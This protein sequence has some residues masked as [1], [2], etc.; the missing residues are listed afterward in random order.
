MF[1]GQR[2]G[3]ARRDGIGRRRLAD[4]G[5]T[6]DGWMATDRTDKTP[7]ILWEKKKYPRW[8]RTRDSRVHPLIIQYL[9]GNGRKVVERRSQHKNVKTYYNNCLSLEKLFKR[10][11]LTCACVM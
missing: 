8:Y 5:G 7:N 9:A 4:P 11:P 3:H 2:A 1:F 6:M 10:L